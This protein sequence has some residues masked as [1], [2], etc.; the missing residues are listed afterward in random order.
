MHP[1]VE[2]TIKECLEIFGE[3]NVAILSNSVGSKEDNGFA[4]A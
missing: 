3:E 2:G 4:E 1:S